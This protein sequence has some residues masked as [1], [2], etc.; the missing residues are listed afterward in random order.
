MIDD[1]IFYKTGLK[2]TYPFSDKADKS[3]DKVFKQIN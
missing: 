3:T 2:F 1:L